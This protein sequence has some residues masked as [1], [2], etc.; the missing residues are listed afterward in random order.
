MLDYFKELRSGYP[1]VYNSEFILRNNKEIRI[2]NKSIFW[3][4]FFEKGIYFVQDLLNR[5]GK[6][7]SGK[8]S[9]EI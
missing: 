9:K 4:Y 2:E 6:F 5:D 8:F 7:F 3:K 1:D